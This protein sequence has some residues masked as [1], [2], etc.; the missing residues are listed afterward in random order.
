MRDTTNEAAAVADAAIKS[1]DPVDR[2]RQSLAHS[3]AMRDVALMRL[4]AKH[5][6]VST[7][8]LVEFLIGERLVR[9]DRATS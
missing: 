2:L 7:L 4:R 8:R 6:G 9:D 5:P 1:M 3:E